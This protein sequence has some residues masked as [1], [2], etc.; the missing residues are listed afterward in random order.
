MDQSGINRRQFL[1]SSGQAAGVAV[2]AVAGV[3]MLVDPRGA[4][5][6]TLEAIPATDAQTLLQALRI[7]YPHDSLSDQYYAQ[8]VAALDQDAKA[9]EAVAA[10]LKDGIAGLDQAGPVAFV[11]LSPGNQRRV[12]EE[13]EASEFFQTIRF[14]TIA[15]FYNNPLVWEAFG[16]EGEAFEYGGYVERGFDD[17]GWLPDPPDDASPPVEL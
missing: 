9:D 14:K 13:L 3:T 10:M 7:L 12:L 17:L 5:A 1:E 16:Y 11:G 8:V 2:V 4:W 15:V 6:M